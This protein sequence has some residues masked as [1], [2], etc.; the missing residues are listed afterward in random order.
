MS[1][2]ILAAFFVYAYPCSLARKLDAIP[3]D[4]F[5]KKVI[6]LPCERLSIALKQLSDKVPKPL[7]SQSR[8]PSVTIDRANVSTCSST[9]KI[10][11]KEAPHNIFNAL[12][13]LFFP[14]L[15]VVCEPQFAQKKAGKASFVT[16]SVT[17]NLYYSDG[18]TCIGPINPRKRPNSAQLTHQEGLLVLRQLNLV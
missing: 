8:N 9:N 6:F 15:L 16:T 1:F 12:T 13:K 7:C 11:G 17:S 14:R 10:V 5:P 4:P 18:N 2:R 3:P